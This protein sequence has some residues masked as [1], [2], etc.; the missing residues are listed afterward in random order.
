MIRE[1]IAVNKLGSHRL[2]MERFKVK[3]A[4]EVAQTGLQL[5]NMWTLRFKLILFG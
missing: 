2:H 4:N 3:K 5:W 1:K